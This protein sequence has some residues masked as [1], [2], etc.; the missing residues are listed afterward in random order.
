MTV[1][2]SQIGGSSAASL[3]QSNLSNV[4]TNT[5]AVAP[6]IGAS[7]NSLT[8]TVTDNSTPTPLLG[9]YVIT[10]VV[11]ILANQVWNGAGSDAYADNN[12]NWTSGAAPGYVGDGMTFA[13]NVNTSPDLDQAYTVSGLTFNANAGSFTL[14]STANNP[15]TMTGNGPIAVN[16][17]NA[18]TLNLVLADTGG[19]LT[20]TGNGPLILTANN[21]YTGL[22]SVQGGDLVVDG[23]GTLGITGAGGSNIEIAPNS[24]QVATLSVTNG[25]VNAVRVII[26]GNS[27]NNSEPGT[28]VVNQAGGTIN[29]YNWFTVGSGGTNNGVGTFNMSG[30]VL[31]VQHQQMEVGNFTNAS[32][33]VNLSGS[34]AINIWNNNALT[35]GA[36][37]YAGSGT[38]NQNGG[39]VTLYSDGGTTPGGT[40]FLS[41]GRAAISSGI[42]TYNLNG[43]VLSVPQV[44]HVSGTGNFYF[45]GGTLQASKDNAVFMTGLT[46]ICVSTNGAIIDDGGHVITIN[47]SL[48]HDP[49]LGANADAGLTKQNSGTLTLSGSSTYTGNTTINGGTLQL[50]APV[51]H[52]TFD[53]VSGTTV[54][55]QGSGGSTMNGTL[56]GTA[57]ISTNA[58]R[59]GNALSIPTGAS[60]AAY[61][62]VSS[63]VVPLN[64]NGN[65]T[66]GMWLKTTTAGGAYLYQGAGAW[67]SGNQTFYLNNGAGSVGSGTHAGGVQNSGG[68]VG[69]TAA[70]N[71]GSWHFV[72]LT[73][74]GG[75]RASYVDGA[76]DALTI[77]QWNRA[78]TGTQ[79]RIGGTGTGEVDGQVGLGGLIDEVY[80][81]NR[82]LSQAEIQQLYINSNP[83]VLPASTAVS[84]ASGTLDIGGLSQQIGSLAGPGNV[85]LDDI[86][87]VNGTLIVGNANSTSFDGAIS[88]TAAGGSLVKVGTGALSLQGASSYGGSTTV[89]NGTLLV[90]GSLSGSGSV[91]VGTNATFG[92][93]GS[94]NG[95][96]TVNG[97]GVLSPGSNSIP[98]ALTIYNNLTLAAGAAC[99]FTLGSVYSSG[100]DQIN[101]NG[102][103]VNNNINP[104]IHIKAPGT[105]DTTGDYVLINGF[106][107]LSGIFNST[108]VWDIQPPDYTHYTVVVSGSQ[109]LLHY[110]A[111]TGPTAGITINPATVSRN[112]NALVTVTVTNGYYPIS[113]VTVDASGIGLSPTL[114]LSEVGATGVWTNTIAATAG[115]APNVYPIVATITDSGSQTATVGANLTVT[116]ANDVWVGGG[117]D[118]FFD[119]NPNWGNSAAPGFVGDSL[120]FAGIVNTNPS[121]DLSYTVTGVTFSNNAGMFDITTGNG[122]ILTLT[123][124]GVLNNSTNAQGLNVPLVMTSAQ[125]LNAASGSLAL[126]QTI[127]N[128]G[129]IL[130]VGGASNTVVSGAISGS[131]GLTKTNTGELIL[132]G[133]DTFTG[134]LFVKRGTVVVDTGGSVNDST[135]W[136]SIGQDGNDTGAL[137]LKGTG[138]LVNPFD[139]N[140]GDIGSAYGVLN[141]QDS[142]TLTVSN[143]FIASA[144]A[145]GSTA[146]GTVNQTGGSVTQLNTAVGMFAIGGRTST[147]GVAV[148]NMSGGTLTAASGIRVGG[149]GTGTFN[150]NGGMLVAN[151]GVNIARIAGSTG[152][153]NENGG[154]NTTLNITSST[155]VNAAFNFNG[156]TVKPT[157]ANTAFMTGL[158]AAFVS[159]NG[160]VIDSGGFN[161]T[162]AQALNAPYYGVTS[163]AVTNGGSGYVSAPIVSIT[164]GAGLGATAVA[165]VAGGAVTGIII[166][167][168][169][170]SYNGGDVLTATLI[171]GGGSGAGLGTPVIAPVGSGSL[172]KN[173]TGTLTLTGGNSY[174]GGTVVNAGS[175]Q[176]TSDAQLGAAPGSPATNITL[177][178]GAIYNNNSTPVLSATRTILLGAGGGYLQS[179]WQPQGQSFVVD[180]LITGAGG[181]GINWDASPVY[182]NAVNT[183]HGDTTIGTAAG[184]YWNNTA[185]NPTLA[186]GIDNALPYG[187]GAGNVVFGTSANNNT[188]TLNLN[189]HNAHINGLT[190]GVNAIVDNTVANTTNVLTVGNNNQTS[191]FAGVI[192]NTAGR[193]ALTKVGSGI[194][195]LTGTNAYTGN[196]TVN[197]GT[198]GITQPT[199][200]TNSTVT[201]AGGAF[202]NLGFAVTNRVA[203]LVLNGA[204]Q[205]AGVY[206]STTASP[207][208]TGS[209]SLELLSTMASNPTNITV[210][211]TG[212]TLSLGWPEDH[213]G[214]MLQSQ[215][216]SLS[217]GISVTNWFDVAGSDLVTNKDVIID[218]TNPTVFYRLHHP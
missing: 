36:N 82:A 77:N 151:G 144:N 6:T 205:P 1:D 139:F 124:N 56:T 14:G 33:T 8:V 69:G 45:N 52:M 26:A 127:N 204:S 49:A 66:V 24:S 176:I 90:N 141:V 81:Y 120:T 150:Q 87:G 74:N 187:A 94:V 21:T 207:Y 41:L 216:N 154:T 7:T 175:L 89:S 195:L 203:S 192:K 142:A 137:V 29:S 172:T 12:A 9:N 25:T 44:S 149:T 95:P 196:T 10:P 48:T 183:Y 104:V 198:L 64:Y 30:G 212:T 131:G 133:A 3:V 99:T 83:Q 71:D 108:P 59:F 4:Y 2:I 186:L 122:S 96:V 170:G 158:T 119:T 57:T 152:T 75:M 190:G 113:T 161:I 188:A 35:L 143:L 101:M 13:G 46:A 63:S 34:S 18:Q 130:T 39:T 55:N 178:G 145:A 28:G 135:T 206:N 100:N 148:Y 138:S 79:V 194:V 62:L 157:A 182:L 177:N 16:T 114:A 180:G 213:R 115:T 51:L 211:V 97:G 91:T 160:A 98:G 125:M 31:N 147:N 153:F 42:F 165:T 217:T 155:G 37:N 174:T 117:S 22:T 76:L 214:W 128:G 11:V 164:G 179:G 73:G 123:A 40:G 47:Q 210:V 168:P 189:G 109:V 134:N 118:A 43:G 199:L 193:V 146:S 50:S 102:A 61:V 201:V 38:F 156:G 15:L 60:T 68:W 167:S 106:G 85:L 80:I 202:L 163:I 70:I 105:L 191:T 215:T 58:G 110:S 116:L 23:G 72:V 140:V 162:I 27:G 121:M 84:I 173:G 111:T 20:K 92:G 129:Y 200:A 184:S 166:T 103:L 218:P 5:F 67:A 93:L 181:L 209:G 86:A 65:W 19:G 17:T 136:C 208:I 126:S 78:D 185:A 32:G 169:G 107:S 159:T 171:G 88:D 112:Q 53:N 54:V 197:G 132:T